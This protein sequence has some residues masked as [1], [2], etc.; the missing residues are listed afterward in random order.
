MD[1]L[2]YLTYLLAYNTGISHV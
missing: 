2:D 1:I